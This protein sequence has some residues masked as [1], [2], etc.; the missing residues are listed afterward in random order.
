MNPF[1]SD[2]SFERTCMRAVPEIVGECYNS[3]IVTSVRAYR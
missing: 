1:F 3:L 2:L